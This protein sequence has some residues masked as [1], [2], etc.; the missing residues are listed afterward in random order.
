MRKAILIHYEEIALKGGNRLKFEQAL[1]RNI[2]GSLKA[3]SGVQIQRE[4]GRF[5]LS[6]D[7]SDE[8]R[9][10]VVQRLAS[11]FGISNFSFVELC[12]PEMKEII[13][14]SLRELKRAGVFSTFRISSRRVDK[15]FPLTSRE[16]NERVGEA[17][18]A[19]FGAKVALK[20]PEKN[21]VIE[22]LPDCAVIGWERSQGLNGLPVGTSGKA[23]VLLSSGIDSPVAAFRM[24]GRGC[25]LEAIHFHSYPM[26]DQ[27][28]QHKVKKIQQRL[29][30]YSPQPFPIHF[31][32]L[33]T[34]QQKIVQGAPEALRVLLYRYGMFRLAERFAQDHG[35][36]ALV[37][38]ESLGQ[39]ASQ[40][41]PNLFAVTSNLSILVLRPLIGTSK[42][43]IIAQAK[44]LQ[45]FDISI[46]PDQDC[47]SLFT[48]R[49]PETRASVALL[50][51]IISDL[52]LNETI[53]ECYAS[54][55][56]HFHAA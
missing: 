56:D 14:T 48:P 35:L 23:L 1:M 20:H 15:A 42:S 33:A 36:E 39:V 27:S 40:T 53:T 3:F 37:T 9:L 12:R 43:E 7:C 5:F 22:I 28:S 32:P 16:V 19:Q 4:F 54:Q 44:V 18:C 31:F 21:L 25:E 50:Q 10:G 11:V 34:L 52:K 51:R 24:M 41:I 26:T 30:P 17:V 46:L 29:S 49:H 8:Q 6:L 38:G 55:Q 2:R 47:C 13:S 45:T